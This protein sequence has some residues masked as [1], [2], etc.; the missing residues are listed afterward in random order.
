MRFSLLVFRDSGR[1]DRRSRLKPRVAA[2]T[3]NS[4]CAS[5]GI[6]TEA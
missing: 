1:G 4:V 6:R 3:V 2:S 5:P